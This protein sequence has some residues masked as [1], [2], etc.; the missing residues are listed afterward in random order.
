M[1]DWKPRLRADLRWETLNLTAEEG[2]LLSRIDGTTSVEGLTHLTGLSTAQVTATLGKLADSG[3]LAEAPRHVAVVAPAPGARAVGFNE[4]ARTQV[5]LQGVGGMVHDVGDLDEDTGLDDE[6]LIQA[7][8][9]EVNDGDGALDPFDDGADTAEGAAVR[10][11]MDADSVEADDEYADD[12]ARAHI[13]LDADEQSG[14]LDEAPQREASAPVGDDDATGEG[15][16]VDDAAKADGEG[17]EGEE[18]VEEGNY[19]KLFETQ[20]HGLPLEEREAMA[21]EAKGPIALAFCFDPV[22]NVILRLMENSEVG[23]PHARLIAR[24]HRTSTGLD[25]L[26]KRSE[27]VRDQQVQRW[28]MANPMLSDPQLKKILSPKILSAVYKWALSRDLPEKNRGKVRLILRSKWG[29]ADGEERANLIF[30]TEGR[31]LTLLVGL[32]LDS[33]ATT[34]LC[35]RSIN[36]VVLIQSLCRF[37]ATPPPVLNHLMRQA[38]VKRQ[39]NLKMLILQHPNCPSEHKRAARAQTRS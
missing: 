19:R 10:S 35:Q 6:A 13:D 18:E 28:L 21:R 37:T 29:V 34:L 27:L 17:E 31:C 11:I 4:A 8:L 25:T 1:S 15:E 12:D 26:F 7:A 16:A 14:L 33:K 22:P 38:L 5:N 2:F 23:F 36:S 30:Q 9:D 3:A 39:P 20:L 32:Q 24:H